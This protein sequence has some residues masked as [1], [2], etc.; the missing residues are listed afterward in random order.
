[1]E[2]FTLDIFNAGN[3]R[4]IGFNMQARTNGDMRAIKRVFL[5]AGILLG[6]FETMSPRLIRGSGE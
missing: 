2:G 1:M 4:D 3:V 6:V 5:V